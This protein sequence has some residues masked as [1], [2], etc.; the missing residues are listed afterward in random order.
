MVASGIVL[1]SA[2]SGA[3][4]YFV[5]KEK[6]YKKYKLYWNIGKNY[7]SDRIVWTIAKEP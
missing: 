6:N 7:E 5:T 3:A 4:A 1:C 2:A